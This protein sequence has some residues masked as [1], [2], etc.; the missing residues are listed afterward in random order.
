MTNCTICNTVLDGEFCKNCGQQN[1]KK[2]LDLKSFFSDLSSNLLDLDKTVFFNIYYVLRFPKKVV[3]NYWAGFRNY[4]YNPGKLLF[5]F[6]TLAGLSS[7][8]LDNT[9]FGLAIDFTENISTQFAFVILIYPILILTSYLTYFRRKKS[10]IEHATA[11]IYI[12][13][14]L[15]IIILT[16]QTIFTFI[17]STN[18][19]D[20][21]WFLLLIMLVIIYTAI[22]FSKNQTF[23]TKILNSILG[24]LVFTGIVCLLLV[25]V[26]L[27]G[28]L[29]LNFG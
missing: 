8:V 9:L 17:D 26:N 4:Y 10:I 13:S 5:Y 3:E 18:N 29:N 6:V 23:F 27:G 25:L 28:G 21:Y 20:P 19:N 11:G 7:Y 1:T 15:G 16:T 22:V 24:L 12:I 14:T 2:K